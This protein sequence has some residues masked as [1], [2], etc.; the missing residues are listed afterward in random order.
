MKLQH[1]AIQTNNI[2][3]TEAFYKDV[4][5]LKI[6][7][8]RSD[9]VSIHVGSSVLQFIENPEFD[10]IYHFAFNIPENKLEEA[11][12]WCEEKVDLLI[13]EDKRIIANF[14]TWNAN[15]VYFYDNNGNLLEF[16]AR[17]DLDNFQI[18]QF[19]SRSVLNISEIG[20]VHE[21]PMELGT[22]LIEKHGLDFFAKNYNS[23]NF[24]A[25]GDDNGLL[26]IVKPYRNWYPTQIPSK[27]NKTDI[28]IENKG[29]QTKLNF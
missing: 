10:S 25:I 4:L 19:S 23:E 15:A 9:S 11:I 17:H 6:L 28:R 7:E 8:K 3:K 27:S 24:A 16:I 26:I 22:E 13:I 2:Q 21:N 20:I 5:E 1:I 12:Q 14:E 29:V 18:K